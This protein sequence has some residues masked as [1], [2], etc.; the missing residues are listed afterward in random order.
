LNNTEDENNGT[1][2]TDISA[3]PSTATYLNHRDTT[4]ATSTHKARVAVVAIND[5]NGISV[6]SK[7]HNRSNDNKCNLPRVG[8]GD[9]KTTTGGSMIDTNG[10]GIGAKNKYHNRSSSSSSPAQVQARAHKPVGS[11]TTSIAPLTTANRNN[12]DNDSTITIAPAPATTIAAAADTTCT[13]IDDTATTRPTTTRTAAAVECVGV[14][15]TL[16]SL[17]SLQ[18]PQQQ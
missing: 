11:N 6:S 12:G 14:N 7:H 18:Q 5:S 1:N 8:G 17:S 10:I 16:L 2:H 3:T 4:T 15:A 9:T 13:A